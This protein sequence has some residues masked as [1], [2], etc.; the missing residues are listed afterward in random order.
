MTVLGRLRSPV[1]QQ[2]VAHERGA[3][4]REVGSWFGKPHRM[5]CVSYQ[6]VSSFLVLRRLFSPSVR[7][8]SNTANSAA[9]DGVAKW[10]LEKTRRLGADSEAAEGAGS[11]EC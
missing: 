7:A 11:H 10:P 4:L 2:T 9:N 1:D 6:S 3:R 5:L 8:Y